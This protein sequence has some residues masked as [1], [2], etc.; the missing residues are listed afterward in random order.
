MAALRET[1]IA[2]FTA[3]WL[4]SGVN[5][6]VFRQRAGLSKL[7]ITNVTSI[8]LLSRMSELVCL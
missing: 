7:L 1:L 2:I 6:L 3:V 5:P 8:T 4:F